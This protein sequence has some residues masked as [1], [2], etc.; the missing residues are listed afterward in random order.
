MSNYSVLVQENV[1][2]LPEQKGKYKTEGT[3]LRKVKN[4]GTWPDSR[5]VFLR[6]F[7]FNSLYLFQ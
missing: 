6:S 1:D 4:L 7:C 3:D 2:F 5:I